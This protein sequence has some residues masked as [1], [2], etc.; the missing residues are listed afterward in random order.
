MFFGLWLQKPLRIAAANSSGTRPADAIARCIDLPR[1]G[2]VLESRA[3]TG[4]LTRGSLR[5]AGPSALS[6]SNASRASSR[7]CAESRGGAA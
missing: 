1:P 4:S 2:P 6:R 3:G 7:S 5:A